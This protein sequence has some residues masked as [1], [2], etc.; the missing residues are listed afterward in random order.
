M[1]EDIVAEV[2][3]EIV[4]LAIEDL[5]EVSGGYDQPDPFI[6]NH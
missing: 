2:V 6:Q 5:V 4:E 1:D 3:D